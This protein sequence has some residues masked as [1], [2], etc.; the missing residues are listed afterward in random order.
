MEWAYL[1]LQGWLAILC[2]CLT[3]TVAQ[4]ITTT[5]M[6]QLIHGHTTSSTTSGADPYK[7]AMHWHTFHESS[8]SIK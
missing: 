5:S 6:Q 7:Y 4:S 3:Y 1:R 8:S 2:R